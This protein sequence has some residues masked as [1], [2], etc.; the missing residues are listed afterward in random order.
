MSDDV[1]VFTSVSLV[2][3]MIALHV[4]DSEVFLLRISVYAYLLLKQ[5]FSS[6]KLYDTNEGP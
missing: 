5:F 3:G 2:S 4:F 6:D 1:T